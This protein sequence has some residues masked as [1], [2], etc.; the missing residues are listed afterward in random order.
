MMAA[1]KDLQAKENLDYLKLKTQLY[2]KN[3]KRV[4]EYEVTYDCKQLESCQSEKAL[5][6][7]LAS[8]SSITLIL[9]ASF[10][11][12]LIFIVWILLRKPK[13]EQF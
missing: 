8:S 12:I 13:S 10:A 1:K 7:S 2:D 6:S 4:D 11:L 5:V 9:I 3:G